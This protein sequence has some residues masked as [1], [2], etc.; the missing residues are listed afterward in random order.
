MKGIR[1]GKGFTLIELMVVVLIIGMLAWFVA[2]RAFKGLGKAKKSIARSK[3]ANIEN[4]LG[5]FRYDCGRFPTDEELLDG[6]LV[7]PDGLEEGKWDGPYLKPSELLDPW[8]RRY[9]YRAEGQINPGSFDL[10]SYG[11]DGEEGGEGEDED[12]YND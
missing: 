11:Q 7:E 6:L 2:P 9:I 8:E 3:M 1:K 5:Q 12:V 10:I 4:A